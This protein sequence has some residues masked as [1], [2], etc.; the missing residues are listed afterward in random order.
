M[1]IDVHTHAFHD[2]IA[3]K[4]VAHL[5]N[6]YGIRPLGTGK[7][8]DLL[9]RARK[10]GLDKVVVHSAA[11]DRSQVIPANNWAIGMQQ[12][13]PE[14]IAF[15]TLHIDYQQ[16]EKEIERL[17]RNNITGL[18]MHCDFQGFFMDDPRFVEMLRLVV[19]KFTIMFHVGDVLPPEKNPSCPSNSP[20]SC[21]LFPAHA[22]LPRI[23]AATSTGNT[24]WTPL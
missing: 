8:D 2:K 7:V 21:A 20:N 4:A 6:H 3:E 12:K 11:T 23:W 14:I 22:S 13:F 17:L 15:G 19:D 18:K 5:E 10:A 24:L 16:P 9:E 1:R